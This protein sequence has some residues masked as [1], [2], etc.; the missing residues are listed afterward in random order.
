MGLR[1]FRL[2]RH[3][4]EEEDIVFKPQL[5]SLI[6]VMVILLVFL[7][8]NFSLEGQLIRPEKSIDLP[9]STQ[10]KDVQKGLNIQVSR[11]YLFFEGD[12]LLAL[13]DLDS[14]GD[15]GIA[16]LDERIKTYLTETDDPPQKVL[17]QAD[18]AVPFRQM[19][20]VMYTCSR[21]GLKDFSILVEQEE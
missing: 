9:V 3:H 5:T 19:K 6:D 11:A 10:Q 2:S 16:S 20:R 8:K 7:L 18:A 14:D 4:N 13:S 21:A 1:L 12:T 15:P 17:L